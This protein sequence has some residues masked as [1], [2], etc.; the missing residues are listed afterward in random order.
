MYETYQKAKP[1]NFTS[2]EEIIECKN[3]SEIMN[4]KEYKGHKILWYIKKCFVRRKY[5]YFINNMEEKEYGKYLMNL[6][7]WLMKENIMKDLIEFD[8]ENYFEILIKIFEDERN[9]EII[10]KYNSNSDDV[11]ARIR[12]LNEQNYEYA[13]KDLSPFSLANYL[14][15]QGKKIK[16]SQK[17]KID[18]NLFILR[19]YKNTQLSKDIIMNAL[20]YI[21]SDYSFVNKIPVENKIK[22]LIL[23]IKNILNNDETF[24]GNDY[25]QIILGFSDHNFDE[26]K[27]F[28]YE[29]TE[30]YKKCL[31]LYLDKEC[32]MYNKEDKL[33]NYIDKKTRK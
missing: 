33:Y 13:F 26:I 20:I 32:K 30:Q 9:I 25:Q 21:L 15:H 10:K 2:Y 3:L 19:I 4:S 8:S 17:I 5:P 24:T 22:K 31:D 16:G 1:L 14:I 12:N 7:F 18:F 29:K 28:I 23:I 27:A 6:I 11:K